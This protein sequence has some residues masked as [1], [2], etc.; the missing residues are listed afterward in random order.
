MKMPRMFRLT[1]VTATTHDEAEGVLLVDADSCE[2]VAVIIP[3]VQ[4]IER[5]DVTDA[6]PVLAVGEPSR[7]DG[8]AGV[9]Q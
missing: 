1:G 6:R 9:V 7:T 5:T 3:P 4:P 8:G 2:E